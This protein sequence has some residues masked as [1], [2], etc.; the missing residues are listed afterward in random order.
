M[1][2]YEEES[3]GIGEEIS[4]TLPKAQQTRGLNVLDK[5]TT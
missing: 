4:K 3:R 1:E 5:E 2:K